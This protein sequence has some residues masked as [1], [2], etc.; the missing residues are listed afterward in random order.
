[1]LNYF[2]YHDTISTAG[3]G[4]L[5]GGSVGEGATGEDGDDGVSHNL[6]SLAAEE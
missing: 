6:F 1:M 3:E 2:F 4:G 5:G